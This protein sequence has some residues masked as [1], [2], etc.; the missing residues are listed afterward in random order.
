MTQSSYDVLLPLRSKLYPRFG[1][2]AKAGASWVVDKIWHYIEAGLIE[3]VLDVGCGSGEMLSAISSLLT[4]RLRKSK[5]RFPEDLIVRI[6]GLDPADRCLS[7]AQ[8]NAPPDLNAVSLEWVKGT[9]ESVRLLEGNLVLPA[10]PTPATLPLSRTALLLLGHTL[11]HLSDSA[12]D[13]LFGKAGDGDP[14]RQHFPVIVVDLHS[15]WDAAVE[16]VARREVHI[17]HLGG[18]YYLSTEQSTVSPDRLV[19][20]V[21]E[22]TDG[23]FPGEQVFSTTQ[24]ALTVAGWKSLLNN[25]SYALDFE[26][27]H[28]S[29]YGLMLGL[30]FSSERDTPATQADGLGYGRFLPLKR[31]MYRRNKEDSEACALWLERV[32]RPYVRDGVVTAV[33]DLGCGTGEVLHHLA[34]S[35]LC[36]PESPPANV[37]SSSNPGLTSLVGVDCCATSLDQAQY[38]SLAKGTSPLLEPKFLKCR[39][40]DLHNPGGELHIG[41]ESAAAPP[42]SGT[43]LTCLGHTLT[44]FSLRS[45]G[46]LLA[47]TSNET[48]SAKDLQPDRRPPLVI[49]DF[50]ARWDAALEDLLSAANSEKIHSDP[51][52]VEGFLL[53]TQC[54]DDPSRQ[55]AI[56]AEATAASSRE[57]HDLQFSE[58]YSRLSTPLPI[59]TAQPRADSGVPLP[60]LSVP[61]PCRP[62]AKGLEHLLDPGE[63]FRGVA[64]WAPARDS[65]AGEEGSKWI[66][67]TRQRALST[68][69]FSLLMRSWNY[70]LVD[71]DEHRSAFGPMEARVFRRLPCDAHLEGQMNA[72]HEAAVRTIV[73]D[74]LRVPVRSSRTKYLERARTDLGVPIEHTPAAI[75]IGAEWKNDPHSL[76]AAPPLAIGETDS[77]KL[78]ELLQYFS[79]KVPIVLRPFDAVAVW[80]RYDPLPCLPEWDFLYSDDYLMLVDRPRP[81]QKDF[82]T[83]FGVYSTLLSQVSA[84]QALK[85]S[86]VSENNPAAVDALIEKAEARFF[87][88]ERGERVGLT[89]SFFMAPVY[90]GSLPI[91]LLALKPRLAHQAA[92]T[93]QQA[94]L[95]LVTTLGRLLRA[96][97]RDSYIRPIVS[98]LLGSGATLASIRES[99]PS[100]VSRAQTR[101]WKSW[102]EAAPSDCLAAISPR[103]QKLNKAVL[104]EFGEEL[105][106][107][108]ADPFRSMMIRLDAVGFFLP[109]GSSTPHADD[110]EESASSPRSVQVGMAVQA[111][112]T[113]HDRYLPAVHLPRL[114][115]A[116]P[117]SR[118]ISE[119]VSQ[120]GLGDSL[121]AEKIEWLQQRISC[122]SSEAEATAKDA[123]YFEL[124]C[125]C[126][127]EKPTPRDHLG[128]SER[129]DLA[130]RAYFWR[131]AILLSLHCTHPMVSL[132]LATAALR[133]RQS[134]T[135]EGDPSAANLRDAVWSARKDDW[136]LRRGTFAPTGVDHFHLTSALLSALQR[137]FG[138]EAERHRFESVSLTLNGEP[139]DNAGVAVL[140]VPLPGSGLEVKEPGKAPWE[141]G[142][143]DLSALGG[144]LVAWRQASRD[145]ADSPALSWNTPPGQNCLQKLSIEYEL[146]QSRCHEPAIS[147]VK[148]AFTG[149]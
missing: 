76:A 93:V 17:G 53:R 7:L 36:A 29:G 114:Q 28:P 18:N 68:S 11:P 3:N 51:L 118:K 147:C 1:S 34:R 24:R 41:E 97:Y 48:H 79:I 73:H 105:N 67:W 143:V 55:K 101:A 85:L 84:M 75:D 9:A 127:P 120:G 66:F 13:I 32:L 23:Q 139:W 12:L 78:E 47:P 27:Y 91:F 43:A 59:D 111:S 142:G 90:L 81:D 33:L 124:K 39:V 144:C 138:S 22:V 119:L 65:S 99:L 110:E 25:R 126:C 21:R 95:D 49:V 141:T 38:P 132:K 109:E 87:L 121:S 134:A 108:T 42:L 83:A 102:I 60:E 113:A 104:E 40:E 88:G 16:S 115:K 98:Q 106:A 133:N 116:L 112:E 146:Q 125:V 10:V 92:A 94:I 123:A 137:I 89:D 62:L 45:L 46:E 57:K 82:P 145:P 72:A 2:E 15:G 19:R 80:A 148:I 130:S 70:L 100:V 69:C 96:N 37:A 136:R 50:H 117:N 30:T 61:R 71:V 5:E 135:V 77:K 44:H 149:V 26:G 103:I 31:R 107:S 56:A 54:C 8:T 52:E 58:L 128:G 35:S 86:A 4:Q 63:V 14:G 122:F 20:E 6:I 129:P 64:A 140:T 131:L 74:L